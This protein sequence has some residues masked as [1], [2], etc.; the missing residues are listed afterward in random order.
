MQVHLATAS[1]GSREIC[2]I[3][4]TSRSTLSTIMTPD[5]QF[6]SVEAT[7]TVQKF[8][9]E[10]VES[11]AQAARDKLEPLRRVL[12]T[13]SSDGGPAESS[14]RACVV[15]KDLV[16][17][18]VQKAGQAK[19]Q[20]FKLILRDIDGPDEARLY[21]NLDKFRCPPC[22]VPGTCPGHRYLALWYR[23]LGKR[24]RSCTYK[25]RDLS[26]LLNIH[27][28]V[29]RALQVLKSGCGG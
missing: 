18:L 14:F 4:I 2:D 13:A 16:V 25:R 15:Q 24:Q 3:V 20:N 21:L 28:G 29:G 10:T 12:E 8:F 23:D 5:M 11:S 9:R 7:G 26:A 22:V 17:S 1:V 6:H 27:G 19:E